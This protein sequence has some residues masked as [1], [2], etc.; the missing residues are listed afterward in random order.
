MSQHISPSQLADYLKGSFQRDDFLNH[1]L[2]EGEVCNYT[3]AGSGHH[4]FSLKDKGSVVPCILFKHEY[5]TG[6]PLANG[7][8]VLVGGSLTIFVQRGVYQLRCNRL[9]PL[10]TGDL[11]SQ[12]LMLKSK[13]E[14]EGLFRQE[15]KK[16]LPPFPKTIALI[17]SPSGAVV[18]DMIRNLASRCPM[19]RVLVIPVAVQGEGAEAQI[20]GAIGWAD[21]YQ[22][23]DLLIVGR[24]GG[25]QEDLKAFNQEVVAR[26]IFHCKTPL[27][28]AV[29]HEP[30]FSIS[31]FVADVRANTPTH[32]A[33]IAVP[34]Q[35][36]L[37]HYL[38]Q[39]QAQM[40]QNLCQ[41]IDNHRRQLQYFADSAGFRDPKH[42]LREKAQML[43]YQQEKLQQAMAQLLQQQRNRCSQLAATLDALSPLAVLGRGYA[44]P[45]T[46]GGNLLCS[47]K[48]TKVG[49]QVALAV[50]DGTVYCRTEEIQED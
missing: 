45:R 33:E 40:T 37:Q 25:S 21:Y 13:L 28:S 39:V 4:Y 17:T 9:S 3:L 10:G 15:Y 49:E 41:R 36:E 32:A 19:T 2:I 46:Q 42:H 6:M 8:Q 1:L 20:A 35:G 26:A 22:L 5:P 31:D 34:V 47:V 38:S 23:A 43:D 50:S 16:K 18:W 29:G 30:D 12:F 44:I 14:Q 24:G 7:M 11:H 27:I 48:D